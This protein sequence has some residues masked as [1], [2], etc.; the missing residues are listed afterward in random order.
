MRK[1]YLFAVAALCL[2]LTSCLKG[3]EYEPSKVAGG[4]QLYSIVSNQ[5]AVALDP[6][7]IAFRLNTLLFEV[8]A[9]NNPDVTI[10][11]IKITVDNNEFKLKDKLFGSAVIAETAVGSGIYTFEFNEYNAASNDYT[12]EGTLKINTLG[13]LLSELVPGEMWDI[14]NHT[15]ELFTLVAG[16]L[17]YAIDFDESGYYISNEGANKWR[18]FTSG[19]G[20][21]SFDK[22]ASND[23]KSAWIIDYTIT[24]NKGEQGYV[25][26]TKSEYSLAGTCEGKP[27]GV[28]FD[29]KYD[30]YTS[31]LIL[32][33]SCRNVYSKSTPIFGG[34]EDVRVVDESKLNPT[35][36]PSSYVKFQWKQ[37]ATDCATYAE[38][39]YNGF[40]ETVQ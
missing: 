39:S 22:N 19:I 5:N 21:V 26:I 34:T 14:Q 27:M 37:G 23:L 10:D 3:T 4:L 25:D 7:N 38:V 36:F 35:Y 8:K 18:L 31:P 28:D 24:Q 33:A 11:N 15:S 13:K 16:R 29:F 6:M 12:H 1:F 2:S 20:L 9:A 30:A 17:R 32:K 40:M